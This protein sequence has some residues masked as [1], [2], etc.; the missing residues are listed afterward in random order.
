MAHRRLPGD[1]CNNRA[2]LL[3]STSLQWPVAFNCPPFSLVFDVSNHFWASIKFRHS[4]HPVAMSCRVEPDEHR[5]WVCLFWMHILVVFSALCCF[6]EKLWALSLS[7]PWYFRF[8]RSCQLPPQSC[9]VPWLRNISVSHLFAC[10]LL[11]F[12]FLFV[13]LF[14]MGHQ[15]SR[16]QHKDTAFLWQSHTDILRFH[17]LLLIILIIELLLSLMLLITEMGI[18]GPGCYNY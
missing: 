5:T 16:V 2:C 3:C 13:Y 6:A 18:S 11:S 4:Q 1:Q 17:N 15:N 7:S 14:E 12:L 9:C 10:F 8:Y